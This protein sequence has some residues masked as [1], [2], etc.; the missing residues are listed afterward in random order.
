MTYRIHKTDGTILVNLTDKTKDVTSTSLALLGRGVVN[1]GTAVAENFIKLLENFNHDEAPENPLPGQ[2]WSDSGT[3]TLK[4]YYAGEWISALTFENGVANLAGLPPHAVAATP[5]TLSVRDGTGGLTATAFHGTA[6]LALQA[7]N[8]TAAGTAGFAT[9][10]GLLNSY[11]SSASGT[12]NTIARRDSS[13]NLTAPQFLGNATTATLA[14]TATNAT[15]ATLAATATT[16]NTLTNKAPATA[17]TI[18]TV[19]VRD[20]A[21]A[22]YATTFYGTFNGTFTGSSGSA[23]TADYATTAG[24]ATLATNATHA[25][26]ADLATLATNATNA[27]NAT[28]ATNAT[29]AVNATN[30]TNATL[31]TNATAAVNAGNSAKLDNKLPSEEAVA[32]T[33]VVRDVDGDISARRVFAT[34]LDLPNAQAISGY[35]HHAGGIIEQWGFIQGPLSEGSYTISFPI[36]FPGTCLNVMGTAYNP[37]QSMDRH[38]TMQIVSQ[39]AASCVVYFQRHGDSANTIPGYFWRAFGTTSVIDVSSITAGTYTPPS[40]GSGGGGS[41]G[42]GAGGGACVWTEAYLPNG[43][44]IV[45]TSVG[46]PV[47]LLNEAGDGYYDYSVTAMRFATQ[48]SWKIVTESGIE[49]TVSDTT[50]IILKTDT[51]YRAEIFN[52]NILAERVPVLDDAGF[53]WELV[54][55]LVDMGEL[56]VGLLSADGG[57]Y[58]AGNAPGRYIFTHNVMKSDSVSV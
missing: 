23:S 28:N 4:F 6:D 15:N 46:D 22:I 32:S 47:L 44:Q 51:G 37:A 14:T 34:R 49:L 27:V 2:F 25:D 17:A 7:N 53:R 31:A 8:A 42:G 18:N 56:P 55:D 41:A 12:A 13:G 21:G 16:A 29:N 30:A 36:V 54:T 43:N 26:L 35:V 3:D 24:T 33:V 40:G 38:F 57:V 1:Y 11:V 19:A 10:A 58:A 48:Q 5:N 52:Q 20:G 50:P 39:S 9:D 45:A